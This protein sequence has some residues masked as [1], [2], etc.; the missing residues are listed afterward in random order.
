[1]A[2]HWKNGGRDLLVR[3]FDVYGQRLNG[4]KMA[5]F[6]NQKLKFDPGMGARRLQQVKPF[7][8][9]FGVRHTSFDTNGRSGALAWDL[10][11][12]ID[13]K[14]LADE[15]GIACGEYDIVTNFG[16]SE[17]VEAEQIT[18]FEN[19]H[20]LCRLGGLMVHAVPRAGTCKRHGVWKYTAAWFQDLA[21]ANGYAVEYL[22]EWDKREHW[23]EK[24]EVGQEIYVLAIFRKVAYPEP[25]FREVWPGDPAR[26]R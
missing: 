15:A 9:F 16:T 11:E 12:P 6:G 8:E 4:L 13:S 19:A 1:L 24:L 21:N 25:D 23:P 17:H 22:T 10:A 3:A 26:E 14:R 20:R 5:E 7:L 18:V 2:I